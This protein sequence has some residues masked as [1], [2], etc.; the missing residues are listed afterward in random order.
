[1]NTLRLILLG[2]FTAGV[3]G[4]VWWVVLGAGVISLMLRRSYFI[5]FMGLAVDLLFATTGEGLL[6]GGFYTIVFFGTTFLVENIRSRLL[7]TI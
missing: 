1:M 4:G 5:L 6:Y 3:A 2:V 7:W